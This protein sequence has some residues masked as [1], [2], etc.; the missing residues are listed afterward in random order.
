M[1]GR[2]TTV[3][4]F[5]PKTAIYPIEMFQNKDYKHPPNHTLGQNIQK[6]DFIAGLK[7]FPY[8]VF[9]LCLF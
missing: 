3:A 8:M 4:G 5:G 2:L 7:S 9:I 6:K 1:A